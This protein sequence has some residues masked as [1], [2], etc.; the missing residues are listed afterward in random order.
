MSSFL[1][2]PSPTEMNWRSLFGAW[3]VGDTIRISP[4]LD[5][6]LGLRDEFTTGWNE[7][8][9]RAANYTF[10]N[11]VIAN[12]PQVGS[13]F[14]TTN[15]AKFL[16]QP[17]IGI[18]WSPL[19]YKSVI[20]AGFGM[21]NDLEDALGYRADQNAPFN[22]V[23]SV[24]S[25]TTPFAV[26]SLPIDPAAPRPTGAKLVPGGVQP[27]M[28]TPTLI[29]WSLRLE[30]EITPDMSLTLGYVGSHGYHELIGVDANEPF[31]VVCPA[32]PCPATYPSTFPSPL[33]G[34]PVPAGSYYVPTTVRANPTIANTWTWFSLGASNYHALQVDAN[35]RFSYGLSLR[36]VYTWSK[37]LDDGDSVNATAA[38]NA[39]GLVSN[40]F[41][42]H[43]DYGL[44]T[45]DVRHIGVINA[46]Y[47]LPFGKG[48][49]LANGGEGWRDILVSG[50][51]VNSI[52]SIQSGFPFTPQLSYNPSNNG[53]TRNPVRPFINPN[54]T[55]PIILGR[56]SQWFNPNA[57]LAPPPNSGFYGNLG[58]NTLIGPGLATWDFSAFKTTTLHERLAL[59]F[60]AE[61]FNLLN[62]ANFNTPNLIAFTASG[63]TAKT[64]GTAGAITSTSTT[65][66]QVQFGLKLIW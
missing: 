18:A 12:S 14:F 3:Y 28:K 6:A 58:R 17:R 2:D 24:G 66:R 57:F 43:A 39:P 29:S 45:Y 16:P 9:G 40:P 31:P 23:Y 11:A 56:P 13:S 64:S 55:G 10:P 52:L 37:A 47:T 33:A 8:H 51:S 60:R 38:A 54:F 20:R 5:L 15:H 21:Y 50:W 44:A 4:R 7:A 42:L 63:S 19:T 65:S 35:R 62:R 22:P 25:A 36:G 32:S 49:S 27:D 34:S 61:I 53:D 1:W 41:N 46:V 30:Q 48:Q 26:S 59:Q